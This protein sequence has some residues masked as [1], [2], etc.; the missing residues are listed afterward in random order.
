M[1]HLG[2]QS[3]FLS[4][5]VTIIYIRVSLLACHL[6]VPVDVLCA[7]LWHIF[8]F[9]SSS[10]LNWMSAY[11]VIH[12]RCI[13]IHRGLAQIQCFRCIEI[14]MLASI[15]FVYELH[16]FSFKLVLLQSI[17]NWCKWVWE[18]E[19]GGGE[20][21]EI[22]RQIDLPEEAHNN[23]KRRWSQW[24]RIENYLWLSNIT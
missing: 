12:K 7:Y 10:P 18:R 23:K 21:E 22:R 20:Q 2:V 17:Q 9:A 15:E 19:V 3:I 24:R 4:C 6:C 16:V 11:D 13:V 14:G 1:H 8:R 5:F